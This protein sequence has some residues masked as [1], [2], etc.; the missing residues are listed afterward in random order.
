MSTRNEQAETD[1]DLPTAL[2]GWVMVVLTLLFVILYASALIGWLKPLADE[3]MIVRLE[4]VIFVIIGYYFGRLPSQ[5][6]ENRLRGE[7]RRQRQRADSA[8]LAK[9]QAQQGREVLEEKVRNTIAALTSST[10]SRVG[11]FSAGEGA[12][13]SGEQVKGE[14]LQRAVIATLSV[15]NSK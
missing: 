6:N 11:S 2:R 15:L 13:R 9:E 14:A 4:P 7:I 5:Q 8:L 10:Q 1:N 12:E 3:K